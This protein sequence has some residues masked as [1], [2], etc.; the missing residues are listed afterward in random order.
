MSRGNAVINP[1]IDFRLYPRDALGRNRLALG[2]FGTGR[3][4]YCQFNAL[5]FRR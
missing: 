1:L 5:R 2:N 3:E 4:L